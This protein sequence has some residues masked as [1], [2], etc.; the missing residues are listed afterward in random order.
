MKVV[1]EVKKVKEGI[2]QGIVAFPSKPD[3]RD[4]VFTSLNVLFSSGPKNPIW[5]MRPS[6]ID[7]YLEAFC[8]FDTPGQANNWNNKIS[9]L[10]IDTGNKNKDY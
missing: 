7:G 9:S 10:I 3:L 8:E 6:N 1:S 4:C 2:Y 5:G